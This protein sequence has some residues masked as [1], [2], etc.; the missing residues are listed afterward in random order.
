VN[1]QT[2]G[3]KYTI[4]Q[5]LGEGG[6]GEVYEARH[7]GTG[8]RVAVKLITGLLS[9][10]ES[11]I[12]RFELE[13]RAAGT[14]ESEHIVAVLDVG[15]DEATGAPFLVM[16][17]LVGE[18]VQHL[19]DRLG[20]M[21][22]DLALRVAVQG[23]LGLGKA[24]A[25][26]IVHRDIKPANL[27]LTERDGGEMRVKVLDFG[28]AKVT[29]GELE[30][31]EKKRPITRTGAFVGSPLYMSPEQTRGKSAVDHRTDLW[32]L[33]IVVYQM[34]AGRTPFDHIESVG[35]FIVA[36]RSTPVDPIRLH[37]PWIDPVIARAVERA[38]AIDP[39]ARYQ[40]ADE[41]RAALAA[42]LPQGASITSAMLVPTRPQEGPATAQIAAS[43]PSGRGAG[44]ALAATTP[45]LPLDS[46][47]AASFSGASGRA[48]PAPALAAH[49][50]V[51]TA[52]TAAPP[53]TGGAAAAPAPPGAA[54]PSWPGPGAPHG[55]SPQ[56]P[57]KPQA[58]PD[59]TGL[60]VGLAF[61]GAVVGA[62]VLTVVFLRVR[63]RQHGTATPTASA[64][65]TAPGPAGGPDASAPPAELLSL[66]GTWR[67]DGG[68][69]Y[70]AEVAGDA[71]RFRIHD[72]SS[73]AAAGYEDGDVQFVLRAHPG[74]TGTFRVE[75]RIRP[76]PPSNL[77]YD[78]VHA[79]KTCIWVGSEREGDALRAETE[80]DRLQVELVQVDAPASAFTRE[81]TGTKIMGCTGLGQGP[82][83][84]VELTLSRGA[85]P[86]APRDA[87]A[88]H[89]ASPLGGFLAVC[90]TDAQC[91]SRNCTGGRCRHVG[92]GA[93]CHDHANCASHRCVLAR[94]M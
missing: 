44:T 94:C 4:V 29:T 15:R 56:A 67:S 51:V 41:M 66:A 21:A 11:L 86:S 70:D 59:R 63:A 53:V 2:I 81:G 36:V 82:F 77:T 71:V 20:P 19:C 23:L 14:I 57:P 33:G 60:I 31:G 54:S 30:S 38:L 13:A 46:P 40:T 76:Q 88:P 42:F 58:R 25:Q 83:V 7:T 79:R 85:V 73:L 65:V 91:T 92:F 22:P 43:H 32:S 27:F 5:K 72:A 26:G 18:D 12:A 47:S 1:G 55:P 34:L 45:A 74:E 75:A 28:I 78:R 24:H 10:N 9:R 39:A 8:R 87:G 89:T 62:L 93:R 16:E 48:T 90:S 35:D 61:V 6:M 64:T 84:P 52:S 50:T 80:G 69:Q 49:G 3:G 68:V 17:Y 37:A